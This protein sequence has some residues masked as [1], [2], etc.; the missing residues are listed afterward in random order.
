MQGSFLSDAEFMNYVYNVRIRSLINCPVMVNE[1]DQLLTLSTCSYEFSG[2]RTVVVARKL[3]E[4]EKA[5]VNTEIATL[6]PFRYR[7]YYFDTETEFYFL[8]TRYY[9]P[10]I[11][12]FM[13]I[14]DISYLD[15]ESINGLNLYAYCGNNPVMRV[16][17]TGCSWFSWLTSGL[18][19]ALGI[20][21]CFVPGGQ[22]IGVSMIVGGSLGL[23]ANAV[24]PAISQAIGGASSM[25]NGLG[26]IS[27]GFS[28]LSFGVPGIIAGI[29][30]MLLGGVTMAFG[31]NEIVSAVS[32]TNYIQEWTGMSDS[33]Y[34]WTYLGLNVA[35]SVG[36]SLGRWGMRLKATSIYNN[37]GKIKPYAVVS[38]DTKIVYYDGRGKMSWSTHLTNHGHPK[39][40]P[41]VPHWH[42]EL[43]HYP[44][45]GFENRYQLFWELI[46]R[47]FG[48]GHK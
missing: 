4:G 47:S 12:R 41:H 15:P 9:D 37:T 26:A 13:T 17:T 5:T 43:P 19:L 6:N 44:K 3:R 46:L 30:M 23:I 27:T 21:L 24:S 2:F 33:A 48:G 8:K 10:E 28:L 35:S 11:G 1:D 32:G 29:G 22:A 16:D 20:A 38:S 18:S 7:S 14:D 45:G 42:V 36:T 39:Q 31:A 34:G 40:H 25:A